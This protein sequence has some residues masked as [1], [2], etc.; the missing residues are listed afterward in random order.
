MSQTAIKLLIRHLQKLSLHSAIPLCVNWTEQLRDIYA[1]CMSQA[2]QAIDT[3][4]G[5][6]TLKLRDVCS[7]EVS[8]LSSL[9]LA[10]P[11]I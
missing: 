1:Q 6:T 4:I 5:H 9:L 7:M 2:L 3:D 11:L 10:K 8:K